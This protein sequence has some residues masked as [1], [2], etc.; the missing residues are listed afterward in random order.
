MDLQDTR[1]KGVDRI[2]ILRIEK[3]RDSANAV[4]KS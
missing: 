4:L 3:N 1:W 2:Y